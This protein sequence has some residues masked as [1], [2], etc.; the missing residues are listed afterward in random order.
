MNLTG[1][2]TRVG[3]P[4]GIADRQPVEL[5]WSLLADCRSWPR[6]PAR[7]RCVRRTDRLSRIFRGLAR[8]P[9]RKEDEVGGQEGC[10]S[11]H[12]DASEI[13]QVHL[14]AVPFSDGQTEK[15]TEEAPPMTKMQ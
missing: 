12:A 8:G 7:D 9:G 3:G 11:G 14:A 13:P 1:S 2:H 10:H 4:M 5:Q 15:R 6:A